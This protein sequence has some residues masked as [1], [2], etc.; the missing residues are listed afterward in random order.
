M[1][2]S[3]SADTFGSQ[4]HVSYLRWYCF[5]GPMIQ[6]FEIW[7][8]KKGRKSHAVVEDDMEM[9]EDQAADRQEAG[10]LSRMK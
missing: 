3:P 8:V 7:I 6:G 4:A 10:Q 5:D 9:M 1:A 2:G